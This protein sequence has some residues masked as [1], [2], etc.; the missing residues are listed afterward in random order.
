MELKIPAGNPARPRSRGLLPA[1]CE[2]AADTPARPRSRGVRT[3]ACERAADGPARLEMRPATCHCDRVGFP[4]TTRFPG[5]PADPLMVAGPRYASI[6]NFPQSPQLVHRDPFS[7]R[8]PS[9]CLRASLSRYAAPFPYPQT[10][11][12]ASKSPRDEIQVQVQVQNETNHPARER[13]ATEQRGSSP[14]SDIGLASHNR[15]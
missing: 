5:D 10:L 12:P 11:V 2:R 15:G 3:A 13:R 4:R 9:E 1:A 8:K 14:T 6:L 7:P